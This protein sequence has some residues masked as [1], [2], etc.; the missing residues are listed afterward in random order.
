MKLPPLLGPAAGLATPWAPP[1]PPTSNR[2]GLASYPAW[3]RGRRSQ[4]RVGKCLALPRRLPSRLVICPPPPP[5]CSGVS[6]STH[7][8]RGLGPQLSVVPPPPLSPPSAPLGV[9]TLVTR[10]ME[11]ASLGA[12]AP[13]T[14]PML[15]SARDVGVLRC[16]SNCALFFPLL[17]LPL[18]NSRPIFAKGSFT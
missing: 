3:V 10:L 13:S 7:C 15:L 12:D 2:S 11:S 18:V 9:S 4:H 14:T 16:W 8:T 17:H 5:C 1:P 6:G